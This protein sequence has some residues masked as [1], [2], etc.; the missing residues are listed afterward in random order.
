[1]DEAQ[2]QSAV[3]LDLGGRPFFVY[4]MEHDQ[5]YISDF[6]VTIL[7]HFWR[8]FSDTARIVKDSSVQQGRVPGDAGYAG[9]ILSAAMDGMR[10]AA[11]LAQAL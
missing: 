4:T 2:A 11:A 9:G 7:K 8:S 1:M 10:V 6:D 3:C 5:K